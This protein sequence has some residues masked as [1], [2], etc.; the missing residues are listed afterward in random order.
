MAGETV[1]STG[2]PLAVQLYSVS[3][4]SEVEK[5][6]VWT[7]QMAGKISSEDMAIAKRERMQTTSDMP[8]VIITDLGSSAGDEVSCDLFHIVNG[9]PIMGDREMEG[10]GVPLTF[11]TDRVRINQT[12]FPIKPGG[13]MTRKRT[14]HNLRKIARSNMSSYFARLNDE[15]IQVHMAGARGTQATE[16]WAVPLSTDPD[17]S[18]I[19]INPVLP[20]TSNRYFVAGGGTAVSDID[21]TDALLLE[22]IDVIAATIRDMPFP[23]EPIKIM[24]AKGDEEITM[25]C[26]MVT[27]R[28][29]HY[30]LRVGGDE[31]GSNIRKAAADA[32]QRRMQ[33]QHPLFTGECLMWN[34]FLIKKMPRAIRFSAGD[35]VQVQ[36]SAG[37]SVTSATVDSAVSNVDRAVILGGQALAIARGDNQGARSGQFPVRWT[38]VLRDHGNS[39]EIGGGMMDGKKKLRFT[40]SDGQVTDYGVCVIDSYAPDPRSTVGQTLRDALADGVR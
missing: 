26:L 4:H 3:L 33:T 25:Y 35:T 37:G 23:P 19:M 8:I 24:N 16:D 10:R 17:F 7:S 9:K 14:M 21:A 20:P 11:S 36:P 12:R 22:D 5:R 34:G 29:W 31:L 30:I 13:R 28:Q 2:D 15:I 39:V 1:I 18:D 38:E 40:G 27:E 32:L 6:C